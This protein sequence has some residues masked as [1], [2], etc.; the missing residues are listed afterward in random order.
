MP[1]VH[2]RNKKE[3]PWY[4]SALYIVWKD[5]MKKGRCM[6]N[7][8]LADGTGDGFPVDPIFREFERFRLWACF[9]WRY[10]MGES[11]SLMLARRNLSQGFSPENCYF[12][13]TP[14]FTLDDATP[15]ITKGASGCQWKSNKTRKN[16]RWGGLSGTRLYCIWKGMVRRCNDPGQKDYPAYGGRGIKVCDEWRKDFFTFYDWAWEHGY[17]TDLSIDRIDVDGSYCPENCRWASF[18]EQK[19]NT[20]GYGGR[21]TNL[22]LKVNDMRRLLTSINGNVVVTMIVRSD[23]LPDILP[24]QADYPAVPVEDRIDIETER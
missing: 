2:Q 14:P 17:S 18:L 22:R 1:L 16:G 15:G 20:R 8:G 12:T 4:Q 24:E 23:Y 19:L 10:R 21:Y 11:D 5:M 6:Y 13:D 9:C 3:N 7:R